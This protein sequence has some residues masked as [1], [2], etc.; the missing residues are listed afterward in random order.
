MTLH[1]I[2]ELEETE[3]GWR[4]GII[5]DMAQCRVSGVRMDHMKK[6]TVAE[7]DGLI[8]QLT[9]ASPADHFQLIGRAITNAAFW[10]VFTDGQI[11]S[12]ERANVELS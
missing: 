1:Q 9:T 4:I 5:R 12:G 7:L 2:K 8:R 3:K 10:P 6:M 11:V